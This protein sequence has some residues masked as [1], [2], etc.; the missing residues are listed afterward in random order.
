MRLQLRAALGPTTRKA[1]NSLL[2]EILAACDAAYPP[3]PAGLAKII[4]RAPSFER[5]ASRL[6]RS[7]APL[8]LVLKSPRFA[9]VTPVA[10]FEVP[11]LPTSG[12]IAAWL[13]LPLEQLDWFTDE[14]RQHGR[15]AIPIL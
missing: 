6:L 1:Q 11:P 14:R 10:G 8:R 15:T 13:A 4:L 9:P 7:D 2:S 3:S 5:A 12:D